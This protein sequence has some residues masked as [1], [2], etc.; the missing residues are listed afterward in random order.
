MSHY[1]K[2]LA[3]AVV[4]NAAI[5]AV[6]AGTGFHAQSLSLV[7]DGVHNFSDELALVFLFFAFILS[8]GVSRNLQR[9]ANLFNS[10]GLIGVS[11]LLIWQAVE[12]FLHPEPVHGAIAI[13]VGLAA[14]AANFGVARLLLK[15]GENNPAIHLAYIH[16]MGDV[17]VSLAPV[18]AG[19][20]VIV[21]GLP[22]FDPIVAGCIAVWIMVTTAQEVFQSRD[23]LMFPEKIVCCHLDH[24]TNAVGVG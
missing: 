18:A 8:Q 20:L 7:M 24:E 2:P 14:A 22:V 1:R 3:V 6:E 11:A 19:L 12:R 5:S 23:S 15:P 10:V 9:I 21:T 16:N 13:A 17:Y 4:L